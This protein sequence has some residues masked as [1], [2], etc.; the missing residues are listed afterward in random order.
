MA[1][2]SLRL[3]GEGLSFTGPSR[4]TALLRR[5]Y[6][7]FAGRGGLEFAAS[8]AAAG[9]APYTP[10]AAAGGGLLRISRGDFRA[11]ADLR[12]G[13]GELSIAPNEQSL[14]AFL[15]SFLSFSLL[16]AGGF[17]LHSAGLVKAGRAYVFL[18]RSGA[19]KSTL[20]GLAAASGAEVISDEINMLRR[21][22]GRFYAYG[23]PFWGE[24]RSE[25]RQGR[26][27]L[28]GLFVL[29]KGRTH[30]LS[31]CGAA[32]ALPVLLRCV[33]NFERTPEAGRLAMDNAASLL[34]GVRAGVLEF[35]KKD[36][37]FIGLI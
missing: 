13:T 15:R 23:S 10:R 20:S 32:A 14:D 24:M 16:R 5:R 34:A 19:G 3:A 6:G 26:W 29:K 9:G 31:P 36:R 35:S 30:G 22:R 2:F 21:E 18:G 28:G 27:P 33:V 8:A 4:I 12:A 7:R 1:G 25:G 37:G 17:M 11:S